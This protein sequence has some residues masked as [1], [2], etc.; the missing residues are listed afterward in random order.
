[1]TPDRSGD[2]RKEAGHLRG[3]RVEASRHVP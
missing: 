3:R 2:A 1:V